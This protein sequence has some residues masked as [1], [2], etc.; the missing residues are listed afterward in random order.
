MS[1]LSSPPATS[2]A[3]LCCHSTEVTSTVKASG[4]CQEQSV[5][6]KGIVVLNTSAQKSLL[7]GHLCLSQALMACVY[8]SRLKLPRG[9][10]TTMTTKPSPMKHQQELH[11]QESQTRCLILYGARNKFPRLKKG[12]PSSEG[13][14]SSRIK[15][16]PSVTQ[17]V[18]LVCGM[19]SVDSILFQATH[20]FVL[21]ISQGS[22]STNP[23]CWIPTRTLRDKNIY[24]L[25]GAQ[26][27]RT[28]S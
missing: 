14:A 12:N 4:R 5:H 17:L 10:Q 16:G 3:P 8:L 28:Y 1:K 7:K 24:Q 23:S 15:S 22:V 21:P 25:T 6:Y 2:G 26:M 27:R 13:V 9:L 18:H 11:T 19:K 20:L